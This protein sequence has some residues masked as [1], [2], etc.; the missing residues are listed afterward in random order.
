M[1]NDILDISKLEA[2]KV[3][4][5]AI[6]FDLVDIVEAAVG[7]LG[8]TANRK[9][10]RARR[11]DR[12][13]GARR[14]SRRPDQ[15]A[16]GAAQSCRQCRQIHR[17]RSRFRRN[18]GGAAAWTWCL[19]G[20]I[21]GY[22]YGHRHIERDADK[23][24]PEFGEADESITRRFGGT[25]LGLAV[26]KQ[27]VELMGGEIGVEH[28]RSGEPVLVRDSAGERRQPNDRPRGTS[29]KARAAPRPDRR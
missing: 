28:S 11:A 26:A 21:F 27:L 25:G 22:R 10:H 12:A 15:S 14:V 9:G 13:D 20:P 29:R 5:E 7:L 1:I 24:V 4:L 18:L 6:D 19:P 16:P 3:E 8:P 17:A 2:G 23:A